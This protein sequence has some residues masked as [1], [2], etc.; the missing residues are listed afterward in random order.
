MD[1]SSFHNKL[2]TDCSRKLNSP[3]QYPM[4]TH[5]H[6]KL[7]IVYYIYPLSASGNWFWDRT[8][9]NLPS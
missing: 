1:M 9:E 2:P 3:R 5:V 7:A 8:W 6:I 4:Y